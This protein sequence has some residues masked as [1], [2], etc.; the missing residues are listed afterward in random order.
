MPKIFA[1][2]DVCVFF[3]GFCLTVNGEKGEMKGKNIQLKILKLPHE[4]D[5]DKSYHEVMNWLISAFIF[6]QL[7]ASHKRVLYWKYLFLILNENIW[8]QYSKEPSQ[9]D[10]SFE[11]QN[12]CLSFWVRK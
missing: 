10:G 11:H 1:Y 4:I 2:L 8:C 7:Q 9:W 12:V 3:R 5:C 6:N